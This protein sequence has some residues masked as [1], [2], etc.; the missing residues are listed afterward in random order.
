MNTPLTQ[1]PNPF[2]FG[3]EFAPER[4][5]DREQ[6]VEIVVRTAVN[7]GRLFLIGPRRYG[8]TSILGAAEA[9]LERDGIT[10]LRFDAETYENLGRLAEAILAQAARKLSGNLQQAGE[11]IKRLLARLRPT[12]DYDFAEQTLSVGLGVE[13]YKASEALPVLTNVL[14]TVDRLAGEANRR[15]LIVIDEFQQVIREG[16]ETAERQIRSVVQRHRNTG[17]VFAGSK[18]RMLID[19]T[20]NPDRAFWKLGSRYVV[21]PI[22]REP[23]LVFL[24]KGFEEAGMRVAAGALEHLID[25]SEDVPYNVQQLAHVC[26]ERL[27]TQPQASLTN[28]F[29]EASLEAVVAME[30]SPY[31][32]LWT[33]LT[34]TQRTMVRAVIEEQGR[35]L[36]SNDVLTRYAIP[37][38]SATRTLRA[39][40]ERGI[41]REEENGGE[42]RYRLEDP[43][44]AAWLRW[45]QRAGQ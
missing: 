43:F 25:R 11:T 14:D 42:I 8:K 39:L 16:G 19:M 36:R 5:V 15:T 20:N 22:P 35:K 6:E 3:I 7:R 21:G 30:N 23:F 32:Q 26:W 2:E 29:V 1:L 28:E 17:Y 33:S 37:S 9:K 24:H 38:S 12:V 4:L 27:R 13:K 41:V 45:A 40:D 18:T 31:T 34:A 44:L 10:V